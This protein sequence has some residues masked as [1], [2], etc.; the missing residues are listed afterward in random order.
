MK[1]Y[2]QIIIRRLLL[3][4]VTNPIF[5]VIYLISFYELY[6]LCRFGRFNNNIIVLFICMLFF[7]SWFIYLIIRIRRKSVTM[8]QH[9]I[10]EYEFHESGIRILQDQEIQ[11]GFQDIKSFSINKKYAYIVLK[12]KDIVILNMISKTP[13]DRNIIKNDLNKS[14]SVWRKSLYKVIWIYIAIIIMVTTTLFYGYKIYHDAVNFNGRFSWVLYDLK[15]KKEIK[16]EHNNIYQ[17]GVEGIFTDI[18]EKL[19]MPETLYVANGFSLNFD[20]DGIIKSFGAFLYGNNRKGKPKSYSIYYDSNKS[21]KITVYLNDYIDAD[22]NEDKL[23]EPLTNTMKVIPL[24]ET[25]SK[26]NERQYGIL[27]YGKR[28][29]GYNTD[30]VVYIDLEGNTRS[31]DEVSSEIIG[32]TVSVYVPEKEHAYTP[33]R[34]NL[35]ED[36]NNIKK[37]HLNVDENEKTSRSANSEDKEFYLSDNIGYKLKVVEAAAGSRFYSL[38]G[39]KDGGNTWDT[40]NEDPFIGRGG[41]AAGITFINEKLGFIALSHSGGDNA[42]LYRTEDGGLSFKEIDIP[43]I[44]VTLNNGSVIYPFDFPG[45]PYEE[46][47]VLNV[48]VGQGSDGDHNGNSSAL[49]QSKDEGITWEYIKEG[50]RD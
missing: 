11:V 12:N 44:D 13:E 49:Y 9:I 48:L 10:D 7:L 15:H 2:K 42:E 38:Y 20:S 18:N 47:G 3:S 19:H 50:N 45:M 14:V 33:V 30:G 37:Y 8:P 28:S 24:K 27:Y 35:T 1:K 32:Y 46:N 5:V 31:A 41:V 36:L 22:F 16:F 25:V 26:W 23:I 4:M 21:K 40:I 17:D 29:F 43:K 39:T 34:Y 6:T